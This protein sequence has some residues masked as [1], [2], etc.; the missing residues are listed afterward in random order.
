MNNKRCHSLS[1][2]HTI[3]VPRIHFH[4]AATFAKLLNHVL[5]LKPPGRVFLPPPPLG[6]S[7]S[8]HHHHVTNDSGP[9][10]PPLCFQSVRQTDGKSFRKY[11][12]EE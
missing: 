11:L 2:L 7:Q 10:I 8:H 6:T 5:S 12:Q 3:Y 9:S 1:P 4:T